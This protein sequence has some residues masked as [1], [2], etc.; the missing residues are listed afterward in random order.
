VPEEQKNNLGIGPQLIRISVGLE[1]P[2]DLEAD[3][4]HALMT[5]QK[6]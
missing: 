3:L 2:A 1:D 4:V 6:G 5:S